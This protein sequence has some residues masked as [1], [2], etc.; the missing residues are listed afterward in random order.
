MA[1][2]SEFELRVH[3][4]KLLNVVMIV[5]Q[6]QHLIDQELE[7]EVTG[8][9]L[10]VGLN[11]IL[12]HQMLLRWRVE[13][14]PRVLRLLNGLAFHVDPFNGGHCEQKVLDQE[15]LLD[16]NGERAQVLRSFFHSSRRWW[17]FNETCVLARDVVVVQMWAFEKPVRQVRN[18]SLHNFEHAGLRDFGS[19]G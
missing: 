15:R 17:I 1:D 9:L 16:V 11:L 2:K 12:V 10:K 5:A 8:W 18:G 3:V 19:I 7:R 14:W 4:H 6:R 13:G